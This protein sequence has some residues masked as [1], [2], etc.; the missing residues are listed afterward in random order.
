MKTKEELNELKKECES[1]SSK[2]NELSEDELK[3]VTAGSTSIWD[4]NVKLK[5]L[6]NT[7][8]PGGE[9]DLGVMSSGARCPTETGRTLD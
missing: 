8:C 9:T 3:M 6:N 4:I 1:L 7:G 2:L 5:G